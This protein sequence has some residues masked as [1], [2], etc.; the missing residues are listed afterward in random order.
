MHKI[1]FV[2]TGNICRSP[3]AEG[4]MLD[5]IKKSKLEQEIH[6][7][8]AATMPYHNGDAP[9]SRSQA[10]A[11]AHGLDISHLRSRT[12]RAEDFAEFDFIL[13]M[14]KRNVLDLEYY[15]PQGDK[16]YN[17]AEVKLLLTYAPEYGTEVPDPYYHD[18][19]DR[20]FKMIEA[21]CK[22]YLA[23]YQKNKTI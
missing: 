8:S 1:L 22:N 19:F 4:I 10:C 5:L 7:E 14:D 15:R 18:G 23:A 9:D 11:L 6:V 21:A 16:R 17:K 3:T 2:C 13:A 20:V 12:I